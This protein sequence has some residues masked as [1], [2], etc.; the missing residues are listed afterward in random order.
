MAG[1]ISP[2][3]HGGRTGRYWRAIALH[4]LGATV[5]AGLTGAVLGGLGA[6]LGA[7]WGVAGV[8]AVTA[9][10]VLYLARDAFAVPIPLPHLR[11]QV[12][13]WWRSFFSTDVAAMLYGIGLGP[14]VTTHLPSGTFVVVLVAA[15]ASGDVGTGALMTAPFGFSRAAVLVFAGDGGE[16][17]E[18]L[19]AR[20]SVSRAANSVALLTVVGVGVAVAL[21]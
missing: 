7:P 10:A 21:V 3:V 6:V 12:P 17:A 5:T 16:H 18:S 15:L 11:A 19:A 13:E 9:V 1:T 20:S 2:V 4:A 14:G 8:V